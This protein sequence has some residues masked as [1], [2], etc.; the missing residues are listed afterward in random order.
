MESNVLGTEILPTSFAQAAGRHGRFLARYM[1]AAQFAQGG[2]VID[3]ACGSGYGAAWL[4]Q[5]ARSTLGLDLDE[6]MLDCARRTW[7]GPNLSFDRHDLH[8]PLPQQGLDLICCF[9]TLEHV[10]DTSACVRN[11]AAALSPGGLAMISIPNGT[12][13][14]EDPK[15]R[16][17]HQV[18][19]SAEQFREMITAGF[20]QVEFSSQ[21]FRKTSGHY[22]R[23][24]L[25]RKGHHAKFYRFV[26]GLLGEAKTWLAMARQPKVK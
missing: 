14:L 4:A 17:Y 1:H 18:H 12:K 19:F 16:P 26:P 7:S 8:Q 23:K 5:R 25:G 10:R 24:V 6:Q 3:I 2:R 20:G 9:E 21:V 15:E 22:L 11:L 13:E